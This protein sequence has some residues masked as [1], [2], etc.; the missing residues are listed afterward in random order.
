VAVAC[1]LWV[2][3]GCQGMPKAPGLAR[4]GDSL[5]EDGVRTASYNE[6]PERSLS[7]FEAEEEEDGLELSDFAPSA[8]A[9]TFKEL[10]GNGPNE[11][12]ARALYQ[13]GDELFRA[14]EYKEAEASFERAA[15]RAPESPLQEDS[16]F[17]LAESQFFSDQ[18]P[19]AYDSYSELLEEYKYT[20]HLDKVV[21]HLFAIGHYWEQAHAADPGLPL[22][23][24][25]T[26]STRPKFDTWGQ[27]LKAYHSVRMNDPTGPLADDSIM[28]TANAHFL[29]GRFEDAAYHYD[30]IRKEYPKSEH[31]FNAH[32]LGMK[33]KLQMYQGAMYDG[34]PLDEAKEIAE[35]T[36]TQF[37]GALGDER[38]R[39]LET[40][41]QLVEQQAERQ[42]RVAQYYDNKKHYGSARIYYRALVDDFPTT[43]AA[44]R[45]N[46]RLEEIR[47]LPANPPDYFNRLT[48]WI[49]SSDD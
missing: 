29:K 49:P 3:A 7:E 19:E 17:M 37:R 35:Q 36:V 4:A 21:A 32:I 34:T 11:D 45:A 15:K 24:Q 43:E 22:S 13:E 23:F 41:N 31:Q 39:L 48:Q 6:P 25:L 30:L 27:A 16:L 46:A 1:L 28:A 9:A 10:T 26:D 38:E 5:A 44:Q 8:V 40:R 42:W 33:S 14:G 2:A 20:Q 47:D 18:Y 12:V